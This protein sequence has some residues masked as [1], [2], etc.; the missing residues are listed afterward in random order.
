[1]A[2]RNETYFK[3]YK[4]F[5][6]RLGGLDNFIETRELAFHVY[7]DIISSNVSESAHKDQCKK[8]GIHCDI[9]KV[10]SKHSFGLYILSVYY[11]LN[12]FFYDF[13][14]EHPNLA[15]R[16]SNAISMLQHLVRYVPKWNDNA[17]RCML[18]DVFHYYKGFRDDF[19]HPNS[20]ISE[21][22]LTNALNKHS[23]V[24]KN[25][26]GLGLPNKFNEFDIHDFYL[27][28]RISK[29]IAKELCQL[30][31]LSLDE[32]FQI[33]VTNDSIINKAKTI[34]SKTIQEQREILARAVRSVYSIPRE[35]AQTIADCLLKKLTAI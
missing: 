4:Q 5:I 7:R 14:S 27:F 11:A 20:N 21:K 34:T 19:F 33:M 8:Y 22:V 35:D 26:F 32:L 18:Y 6:K 13:I 10:N 1:M 25:E 17:R 2:Q 9:H 23:G 24:I 3:S 16:D 29:Q 31:P 12:K 15:P 28:S 30:L